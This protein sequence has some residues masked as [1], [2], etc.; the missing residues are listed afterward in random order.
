MMEI[1][2]SAEKEDLLSSIESTPYVRNSELGTMTT[3]TGR[4]QD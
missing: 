2:M 4:G 1:D 3:A